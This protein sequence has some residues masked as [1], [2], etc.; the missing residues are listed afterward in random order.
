M[1]S[2]TRIVMAWLTAS[3]ALAA[4]LAFHSIAL[5]YPLF[6]LS[7]AIRKLPEPRFPQP[8]FSRG[9]TVFIY[10]FGIAFLLSGLLFRPFWDSAPG[11]ILGMALS[12]AAF[13]FISVSDFH[14][15]RATRQTEFN[16]NA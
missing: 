16:R 2:R 12:V 14:L 3:A 5:F 15:Y 7:L 10:V 6:L 8:K 9:I 13:I 11:Q 4:A 1:I